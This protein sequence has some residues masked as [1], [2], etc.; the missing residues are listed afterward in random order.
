M[1][2]EVGPSAAVADLRARQRLI[3]DRY[4]AELA[5]IDS[6]LVADEVTWQECSIQAE[7]IIADCADALASGR[8]GIVARHLHAIA[9]MAQRRGDRGIRPD[10]S[11]R[12]AR[13]LS[14]LVL[15]EVAEIVAPLADST[16]HLGIAAITLNRAIYAR[17]EA[18][19]KGYDSFLLNQVRMVNNAERRML[20][21]DIHDRIG[22]SV[23]VA[24]RRLELCAASQ[25]AGDPT[26]SDAIAALTDTLQELSY[27]TTGLRADYGTGSLR[28]A[29]AAFVGA[30]RLAEPAVGIQV[31]GVESWVDSLVLDEIFLILR[32]GLRNAFAHAAAEQVV[33]TV[34]IAP[35]EVW[36]TVADDGIGFDP[37]AERRTNGLD[38]MRER[39]ELL[40]GAVTV[41]SRKHGGTTVGVWIPVLAACAI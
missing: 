29:L 6:A 34:D 3:L 25:P 1:T 5:A 4:R 30:M 40:S 2:T 13:V 32:E 18:G 24:M 19:A 37:K 9:D 7:H 15:T 11:V 41:V 26:I 10:A 17:L 36:A 20:A 14:E 39:A 27:I 33:V 16:R 38:S 23:S 22:N 35:H 31:N 8:V 12:A 21:R 28:D